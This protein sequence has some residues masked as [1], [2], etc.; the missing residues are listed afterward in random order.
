MKK[1]LYSIYSLNL[2][3]SDDLLSLFGFSNRNS[4][5]IKDNI[6]LEEDLNISFF[7]IKNLENSD[8]LLKKKNDSLIN[9]IETGSYKG[10]KVVRGL[11]IFNQRTKTN[12]KTSRLLNKNF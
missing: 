11:P 12:S 2:S 1:K 8:F 10:Y 3:R 4:K 7:L 9:K 5:N 6:Y